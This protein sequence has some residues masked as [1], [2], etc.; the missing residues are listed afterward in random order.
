[1]SS[2]PA[3]PAGPSC[4]SS[5]AWH[6]KRNAAKVEM[7]TWLLVHCWKT[8]RLKQRVNAELVFYSCTKDFQCLEQ[9]LQEKDLP[10][11]QQSEQV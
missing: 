8:D 9:Q 4:D 7:V 3:R 11:I 2:S 10:S 5:T 1:M 6:H